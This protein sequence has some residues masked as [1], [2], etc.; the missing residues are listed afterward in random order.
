MSNHADQ[1][2][3]LLVE[4]A[5]APKEGWTREQFVHWFGEDN[6][7]SRAFRFQGSLGFGGK[8]RRNDGRFYVTCYSED[9]TAE[10]MATIERTDEAL[11]SLKGSI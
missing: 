5:G 4:L 11:S 2:Y 9:E 8:F 7:Y 6:D 3:N 1:I 10:R